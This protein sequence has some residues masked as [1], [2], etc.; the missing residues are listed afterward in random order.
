MAGTDNV[1]QDALAAQWDAAIEKR[2]AKK[3]ANKRA[4]PAVVA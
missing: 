3:V 4:A 1:D 2:F